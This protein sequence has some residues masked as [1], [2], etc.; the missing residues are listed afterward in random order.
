MPTPEDRTARLESYLHD[1][2]VEQR[3]QSERLGRIE[4][5]LNGRFQLC[6]FEQDR[7]DKLETQVARQNFIGALVSAVVAGLTAAAVWLVRE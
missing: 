4:G 6:K 1:I 3:A 7:I 5:V 2:Q